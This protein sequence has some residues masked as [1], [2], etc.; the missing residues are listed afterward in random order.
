MSKIRTVEDL[1][2]DFFDKHPEYQGLYNPDDDCA[3]G[4]DDFIP[5]SSD[6]LNCCFGVQVPCDCGDHDFHIVDPDSVKK[7]PDNDGQ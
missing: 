4:P 1:L 6:P 3:C 2:N 7:E 5:C